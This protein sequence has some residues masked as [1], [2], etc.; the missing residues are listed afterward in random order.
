VRVLGDR[1]QRRLLV[2]LGRNRCLAAD[3]TA[4]RDTGSPGVYLGDSSSWLVT[5][6]PDD[7]ISMGVEMSQRG[8]RLPLSN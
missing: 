3:S 7:I 2:A 8:V 4:S 5:A 6:Y 1:T